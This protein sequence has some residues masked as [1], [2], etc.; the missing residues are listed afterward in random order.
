MINLHSCNIKDGVKN[1]KDS[2]TNK[3]YCLILAEVLPGNIF[4]SKP[5]LGCNHVEESEDQVTCSF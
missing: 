2:I 5:V 4:M 3:T 1:F